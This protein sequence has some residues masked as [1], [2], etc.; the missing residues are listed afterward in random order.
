M[1]QRRLA[2]PQDLV[3]YSVNISASYYTVHL[4]TVAEYFEQKLNTKFHVSQLLSTPI[5]CR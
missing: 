3:Q 4:H 1:L 2:H 5:P